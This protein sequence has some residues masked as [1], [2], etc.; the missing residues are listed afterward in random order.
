MLLD[1]VFRYCLNNANIII[2]N[3]QHNSPTVKLPA[4]TLFL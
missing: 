1:M 3:M 2:L 4:K